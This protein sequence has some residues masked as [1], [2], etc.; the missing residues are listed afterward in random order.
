MSV[1]E[2]KPFAISRRLLVVP[3]VTYRSRHD[4]PWS[5]ALEDG[6]TTGG[7]LDPRK[8]ILAMAVTNE[9]LGWENPKNGIFLMVIVTGWRVAHQYFDV[10]LESLYL[11]KTLLAL[12]IEHGKMFGFLEEAW[13][14]SL[15]RHWG[16]ETQRGIH[17]LINRSKPTPAC[18]SWRVKNFQFIPQ[19]PWFESTSWKILVC[20]RSSN[21][22]VKSHTYIIT[23]CIKIT[24]LRVIPTMT[25]WV[26][27]VRWGLSLRIWWEEWRIWEHWFQVSLA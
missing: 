1:L 18:W 3:K 21:N 15:K 25:C 24:L 6:S 22:T 8:S 14:F 12:T 27:V 7:G 11:P 17:P 23:I 26:E 10:C 9:A 2:A 19:V 13:L 20:F 5:H 4:T 16:L